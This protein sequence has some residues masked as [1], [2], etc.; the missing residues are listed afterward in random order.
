VFQLKANGQKAGTDEL[1]KRLAI[2][3]QL[4]VGGFVLEIDSDRPIFA[5]LASWF[6]HA[7]PSRHSV[8]TMDDT[9]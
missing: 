3:Q 2:T 9:P 6:W 7:S 8:C 5:G 4:T 1:E